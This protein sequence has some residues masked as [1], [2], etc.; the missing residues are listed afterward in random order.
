LNTVAV[1]LG[2]VVAVAGCAYGRRYAYHLGT[3]MVEQGRAMAIALAVQDQRESVNAGGSPDF[4]G[5]S[6]GGFGNS[7]DV[8]TASGQPLAADFAVSI[9]RGLESAGYRVTPV[10]VMDRARTE[11]VA[12]TLAKT[13]AERLLAV[14]IDVWHSDTLN[15]SWLHYGVRLRVFDA[16][17]HELGRAA[18]SGSDV[19]GSA[20]QDRE[21]IAELAMPRACVQK[22]EK[23]LNDPAIKRALLPRAPSTD[24][25]DEPGDAHSNESGRE[26]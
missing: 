16:G 21:N 5:V 15:R 3:P 22:L 26:P 12:R 1:L 11:L 19:L 13:N 17:G 25:T 7:F 4:V 14:T 2:A 9:Q 24:S 23:L 18:V 8:T 6:R 20:F 10:R